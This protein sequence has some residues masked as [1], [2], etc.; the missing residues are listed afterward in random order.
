MGDDTSA[1]PTYFSL[2]SNG[3]F[4]SLSSLSAF[5]LAGARQGFSCNFAALPP[6]GLHHR[7][8]YRSALDDAPRISSALISRLANNK[9]IGPFLWTGRLPHGYDRLCVNPMGS[10]PYKYEPER[11]RPIDDP[12]VNDYIRAPYFPMPTLEL[13]R[14]FASPGC[15][16][17]LQDVAGAFP[18]LPLHPTMWP[19]FAFLWHDL[20]SGSAPPATPRQQCL[21]MHT[22]GLFGPR[23]LPWLWTMFM[24]FVTMV[25]VAEGLPLSPP[26]LDDIPHVYDHKFEVDIALDRYAEILAR[27]GT[28]EKPLKRSAPFQKGEILGRLFNSR[29]FTIGVPKE[30]IDRFTAL[31]RRLFVPGS[32]RIPALALASLMGMAAF[33][34]SVLPPAFTAY[35]SPLYAMFRRSG[36]SLRRRSRHHTLRVSP[37]ARATAAALLRALPDFNLRVSINPDLTHRRGPRI[38]S[39]ASGLPIAGWGYASCRCFRGDVFLGAARDL[40]IM[41]LELAALVYGVEAHIMDLGFHTCVLPLYCDNQVVCGWIDRGRANGEPA[42]RSLANDMLRRL[43]HLSLARNVLFTV[44]W[45]PSAENI[46]ADA[47]S[48]LDHSRFHEAYLAHRDWW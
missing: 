35:L 43:F 8:N 15:W 27:M 10:V 17:G 32:R 24:L 33:I 34:A 3:N 9:T 28:P 29:T 39:D 22:H 30:K 45:L 16:F 11:S 38:Y 4:A 40:D 36:V 46:C 20:R 47:L 31:L 37:D 25:A 42:L 44:H 1:A 41:L 21:Y 7:S 14:L 18:C 26:Y 13:V 12:W 2:I 48:R 5:V 6:V 23:D 19:Y